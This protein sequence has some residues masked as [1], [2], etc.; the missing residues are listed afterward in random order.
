MLLFALFR[1]DMTERERARMLSIASLEPLNVI[2]NALKL[3]R[4]GGGARRVVDDRSCCC[5]CC[6]C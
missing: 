3:A 6:W 2:G 4:R 1:A 5:C